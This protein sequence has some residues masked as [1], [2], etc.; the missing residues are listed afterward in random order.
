MP[1][2]DS[3]MQVP[4]PPKDLKIRS[5]ETFGEILADCKEVIM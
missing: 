3:G 1:A 4:R 2:G 5:P